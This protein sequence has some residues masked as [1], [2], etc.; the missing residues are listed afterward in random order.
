MGYDYGKIWV[1]GAAGRVGTMIHNMLDM[2]DV[3]LLETDVEEL[4]ITC[5]ADVNLFGSRNRP[6][7]IINCAG[8]TDVQ[9]CEDNIEQAYK[10]NAL[11]AR[12]LS[13]IARK[14]DARI[15]QIS[16][17]DIFWDNSCRSFH[18][19]DTPNPRT[20]YGKSKLAGENFV[21]E[22]APKHL[23]IRSSWVYGKEG[24]NF[25]NS[26]IEQV[27][28]GGIIEA[29]INEY[30]CPTSARELCKVI[31]RL[32]KEEGIYHAV[33]SGSC[34]RYELAQEI[35]RIMGR[36]DVKLEPVELEEPGQEPCRYTENC[37]STYIQSASSNSCTSGGSAENC[38][39][40]YTILDNMMLRM[41]G[42]E[43]PGPWQAA[44]KEY[45]QELNL[46]EGAEI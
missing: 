36:Q 14:I 42:I 41:C 26:I 22:L 45:L 28:H 29:A 3:E 12:N 8:M 34:S 18:E 31:L 27:Q 19:F 15:I 23:I 1:A 20:V 30:A 6:N 13:A 10:V 9:E 35:L 32:I 2:R 5:A 33:C 40:R 11:G 38:G 25:V 43:E 44:L 7:T 24:R 17:D 4:D 39:I 21:K 46:Q 37:G 16:T